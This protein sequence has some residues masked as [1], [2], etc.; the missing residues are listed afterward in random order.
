[1][2]ITGTALPANPRVRV[3]DSA[4]ATVVTSSPTGLTFRAPA[5]VAGTYDVHVFATDGTED[6]LTAALTYVDGAGAGTARHRHPGHGTPGTGTPGTPGTGTGTGG[7]AVGLRRL[8]LAAP[9]RAPARAGS[10]WRR[11]SGR[12]DR[13]GRGATGADDEVRRAGRDLVDGLLVVLRRGRDLDP[14][15]PLRPVRLPRADGAQHVRR[16]RGQ[17]PT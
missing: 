12:R 5:R 16:P 9:A 17:A 11:G 13:P 14:L 4:T 2:T 1:M 8:R 6:V 15:E 10:G 7:P 3:G